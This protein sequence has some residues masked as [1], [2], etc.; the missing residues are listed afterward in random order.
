MP[1]DNDLEAL[2]RH[3]RGRLA[4]LESVAESRREAGGTVELDQTRSGRL[5][6]MDALQAQAMAQAGQRR[7]GEE[8]KRIRAALGRMERGEYGEC[9]ACGEPIA[10]ARLAADPAAPLCLRCAAARE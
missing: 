7:A 2:A 9:S 5:S 8:I 6:R 3:L 1:E 10:P 4:E